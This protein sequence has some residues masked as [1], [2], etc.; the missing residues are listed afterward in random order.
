MSKYEFYSYIPRHACLAACVMHGE[1]CAG[2]RAKQVGAGK[3]ACSYDHD[4]RTRTR[5]IEGKIGHKAN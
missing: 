4:S 5:T 1:V 3:E 2:L